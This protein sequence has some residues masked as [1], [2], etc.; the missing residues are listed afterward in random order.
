M[1][2]KTILAGLSG[3]SASD[4]VIELACR[5][6][7]QFAAY[8]E[9][10]HVRIDAG[11]LVIAAGAEGLAAA[12]SM[13]LTDQLL[14]EAMEKAKHLQQAFMAAATRHGLALH[15]EATAAGPGVSWR[16][17]SG[18]APAIVA[19]RAR[20]FDLAVLG[21]SDR[22]VNQPHTDVIEETLLHSGRPVLLAPSEPPPAFGERIAIGWN[23]SD[24]AVRSVTAS[25]PFLRRARDVVLVELG[26][27]D[28]A[29]TADMQAYLLMLGI[30]S[31]SRK[32]R[33]V[34]GANV[35]TELLSTAA[36]EGADLLVLGGYSRS[37]LR[38]SVFGGTTR[39]VL[40][41]SRL[42]LLMAH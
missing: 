18:D 4:S 11:E 32:L 40:A 7:E 31:R 42:P 17:E 13:G 26:D 36:D 9:G 37:P 6:A 35:G 5:L 1:I 12:T 10:L 27:S 25:L 23:G 38:Q 8:V 19:S 24:E 39:Q 16:V 14:A 33:D 2:I 22:V 30:A 20:F 3:G 34:R 29:G 41:A 21:R 15:S 28:K